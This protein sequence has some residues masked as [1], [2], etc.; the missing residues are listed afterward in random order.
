M[1]VA[2]GAYLGPYEVLSPIGAGGMGEVYRARDSRLGREVAIQLL[3][4]AFATSADRLRRFELEVNVTGALNHPNIVAVHDVGAHEGVP[5]VVYEMLEGQTLR[6]WLESASR[7][8]ARKSAELAL[9]MARGLAAAHEKGIVHRDLKPENLFVT[10]DGRL[11]ILDFGLAKREDTSDAPPEPGAAGSELSLQSTVPGHT[12][13]GTRLGTVAYMSPEQV[14][15]VAVDHRS[16]IFSFG[17]VLYE[18]VSGRPAFRKAT[19]SET[20]AAILTEDPPGLPE[21]LPPALQTLV[22]RCLEKSSAERFQSARDLAFALETMLSGGNSG[23]LSG[24]PGGSQSPKRQRVVPLVGA[25]ALIVLTALTVLWWPGRRGPGSLPNWTPRQLTS[26]PGWETE[27]SLSPDGGLV[28]YSSSRS[29]NADIWVVDARG[30]T[31]LRL[32]DDAAS[33]RS[34]AWFPDGGALAFVSDRLGQDAIWKVSRLGGSAV[35]LVP[36][37]EDPA[38]SPDGTRVAFSRRGSSGQQRIAVAELADPSH[39]TLL[40]GDGDGLWEH[41]RPAWS[42]DG[43]TLCY[44]AFRD[45]WLMPTQG[46]RSKRLTTDHAKDDH[47][48]WSADGRHVYFSSWRNGT[49]ALWRVSAGGGTPVRMTLGTGPEEEPSLSRDGA[50]L[51]YSTHAVRTDVILLDLRSRERRE[52]PGFLEASTPTFAP[53]GSS[54]IFTSD[55][56]GSIDL[57]LQPLAGS[58]P[59]GDPLRLTDEPG[60]EVV[61]AFSPD[62]RWIAY[63]RVFGERRD[64]C[65]LPV[66]GGR[67]VPFGD[68]PAIHMHPAWSP[69]G[70]RLA[71]VSA[72]NGGDHVWVRAVRNGA[73]VGEARLVTSG[74]GADS[75]PVWSADGSAIAFIR[76][77]GTAVDVWSV[78]ADGRSVPRRLTQGADARFVRRGV[79]GGSLLVSGTWGTRTVSLKRLTLATGETTAF[80]PQI[81]LGTADALGDFDLSADGLVLA[82]VRYDQRGDVWL[83]DVGRGSF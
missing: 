64:I 76:S 51:A 54:V 69:D 82:F 9:Q 78:A 39:V 63:G 83:L 1:A 56:E 12:S 13:P 35:L 77:Q 75:L 80:E 73:P 70:S 38:V 71:F 11:K 7:P 48:A 45:L 34:P 57:W 37:A 79:V 44:A 8:A 19:S 60:S 40:T 25:A 15:G 21:T 29:G 43:R 4:E 22:W 50:R 41:R 59:Q 27:P 61:P 36:D 68:D 18:M 30:G 66:N 46:G 32:T 28:A 81:D 42:P 26:D 6:A 67:P 58:G 20:L 23:S 16:D 62:G 24:R 14:R 10:V 33:D 31:S 17:T 72:R 65:I 47:P 2:P 5:Y 53:D 49:L 52:I 3:P 74:D 55:R